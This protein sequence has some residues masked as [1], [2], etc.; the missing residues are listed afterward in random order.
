MKLKNSSAIV[1]AVVLSLGL[2]SQAQNTGTTIRHV[3]VAERD[4][5]LIKAEADM[6][7][8]DYATAETE[9]DAIVKQHPQHYRAWFD[10][11]YI[12]NVTNRKPQA[13]EAYRK[14]V[15][16]Q[17][18]VLESNL[19]LAL[20]LVS[21]GSPEAGKYLRAAA[22]LKPN[23]AELQTMAKAWLFL[24]QKLSQTDRAN[25]VDAYQQAAAL[26]PTDPTPH[27]QL[28]TLYQQ[29]KDDADAEKE[30]KKAA[31]I[32]PTN[33]DALAAL[34]NLYMRDKRFPDAETVLRQFLQANPQ[35]VNAHLQLGRV[36]VVEEKYP[37]AAAEFEKALQISPGDL[38]T[39][40]ELA[41]L[42]LRLK[43]YGDAIGT[44]QTLL[45]KS[46]NDPEL[47]YILG[48]ALLHTQKFP[49]AQ[50][51]FLIAVKLKPNFGDAYGQLALAASENK[52][53]SLTIQALDARG[54]L[55]PENAGTYFLRATS[56][57]HLGAFKEAS[58]NYKQFLTVSNGK[59][60]DEEWKAKH[61][62][63]AIDPESRKKAK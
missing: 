44:A 13:I 23:A 6:Q 32:S 9:L 2:M 47:H 57:D 55:E 11:G 41:S 24:G 51:E 25:A 38:D 59:F 39:L 46:P 37:D 26:M 34:S 56:Y 43:K 63:I 12:Y 54:K 15:A 17:P 28:G 31:E 18:N 27:L 3:R 60:P 50:N 61:R 48:V 16:A 33:S 1:I 22:K 4:E 10:L 49:E 36:L 52:Q 30:F 40:R 45:A 19:N 5:A 20:L 58:E 53:Y 14:S 21:T 29:T 42:Q 62:L 35:S 7:K 8:Q